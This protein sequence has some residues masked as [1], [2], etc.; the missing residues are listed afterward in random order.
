MEPALVRL[1]G[2]VSGE[3]PGESDSREM[4]PVDRRDW[5]VFLRDGA[6][7]RGHDPPRASSGHRRR[8]RRRGDAVAVQSRRRRRGWILLFGRGWNSGRLVERISTRR[9]RIPRR[10]RGLGE[11]GERARGRGRRR[12]VPRA[13]RRAGA[14]R[15]VRDDGAAHPEGRVP[16]HSSVSPLTD[17]FRRPGVRDGRRCMGT[18]GSFANNQPALLACGLSAWY[19]YAVWWVF[20]S[21]KVGVHGVDPVSFF[22]FPYGQSD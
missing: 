7:Q 3:R 12:R 18:L 14:A 16:T 11:G 6:Q 17:L 20:R 10:D 15:H 13:R 19:T 2:G 4:R 1:A 9:L 21:G 22:L 8:R 5:R